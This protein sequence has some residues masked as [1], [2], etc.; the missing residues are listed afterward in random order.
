[1]GFQKKKKQFDASLSY[2]DCCYL[3]FWGGSLVIWDVLLHLKHRCVSNLLLGFIENYFFFYTLLSL[4]Q[5]KICPSCASRSWDPMIPISCPWLHGQAFSTSQ[6]KYS[7]ILHSTEPDLLMSR[8]SRSCW[9]RMQ[10]LESV[11]VLG[12]LC[13]RICCM[14]IETKR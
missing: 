8:C 7:C 14:D 6:H 10:S 11:C 2:V 9:G 5:W 4:F 1:M 13:G 3:V 12:F